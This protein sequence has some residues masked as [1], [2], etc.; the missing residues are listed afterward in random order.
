MSAEEVRQ[1]CE[2]VLIALLVVRILKTLMV[3]EESQMTRES[4]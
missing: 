4:F 2:S 3:N 1:K